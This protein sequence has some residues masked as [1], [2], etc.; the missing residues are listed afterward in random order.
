MFSRFDKTTSC[1]EGQKKIHT[2]TAYTAPEQHCTVK[3]YGVTVWHLLYKM[4]RYTTDSIYKLDSL[5]SRCHRPISTKN[6]KI[7][8][9]AL[10]T[11]HTF[12]ITRLVKFGTVSLIPILQ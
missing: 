7:T 4:E 10:S 12:A 11:A 6:C 5:R 9:T 2:D 3:M 8:A 1:D